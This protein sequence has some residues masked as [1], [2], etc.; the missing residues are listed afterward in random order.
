MYNR[1]TSFFGIPVPAPG[2][3]IVSQEEMRKFRIIENQLLAAS[4]GALCAIYEDGVYSCSVKDDGSYVVRCASYGGKPSLLGVLNYGLAKSFSTI[5]W[6]GLFA[7]K[8]YYLY[9]NWSATLYEDETSFVVSI[10]TSPVQQTD[11]NLLMATVDLSNTQNIVIDSNPDG[12]LYVKD[13]AQHIGD[14]INPHSPVLI[15]DVLQ[16]RDR[17]VFDATYDSP[18]IESFGEMTFKDKRASV[19][20]SDEDNTEL[21][22]EKKS[23]VGAIN[24]LCDRERSVVVEA[25]YAGSA[26]VLCSVVGEVLGVY[27][28]TVFGGVPEG[29]VGEVEVEYASDGNDL[30]A[31]SFRVYN[32]GGSGGLFRALVLYR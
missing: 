30:N 24:E 9:V 14:N 15:Q 17:I 21:K 3:K 13:F 11:K 16:V 20:L 18:A 7:G 2:D 4:R 6:E 23:V 19:T 10:S 31:S 22:T 12:K 26:G 28:S 29:G 8:K 32:S 1:R 5:R 27:V 25:S